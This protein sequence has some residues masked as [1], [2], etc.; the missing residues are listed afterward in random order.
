[1]DIG[2]TTPKVST[3]PRRSYHSRMPDMP[4][5]TA[6]LGY[7][8]AG[9]VFHCPFVSAVPGLELTAIVQRTGDT[10]AQRY[11]NARILRSVDEAFA[12]PSLDL[13]VV[14]TPNHTHF[15]MARRALEANKHVVVDKP[16]TSTS[17]Q[18]RTLLDLARERGRIIAPYH[19]RRFDND[20]RT[21]QK[22]LAEGS[23]GRVVQVIS[24]MD[25]YR[26]MQ[27]PNTWKEKGG[28]TTGI[29]F[30]L[31]PHLVDM[32]VALF[33][34][35]AR[36]TASVRH[37]RETTEI[38][39]AIDIV[40]EYDATSRFG[41]HP[42]RFSCHTTMLGADPAARFRVHGTHG[43]Y[44]KFGLDPQ[45]PDSLAG[46]APPPVGSSEPW[47]VEPE[48]SWGTLTLGVERSEP[49]RITRAPYP[50]LPGDYRLFYLSVRDAI[51]HGKP[52]VI[53]SEDG[54]RSIR[55]LELALE[56]SRQQRT[57]PIDFA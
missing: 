6:V 55:L 23:L 9:K 37:E 36:I 40:L 44:T 31:G 39:D 18:A 47:G 12:D 26:P 22:V 16:F 1:M 48:S 10:A 57:L 24:H 11:P 56:S 33:G 38:D 42:L 50:T 45:E 21:V 53:P 13:I 28:L 52:L 30:D 5:R 41:A 27:R 4:I 35:P 15:E 14:G 3:L 19:N 29:L 43:S 54:F 46:A 51:L 2:K 34:T 8:L 49:I 20:F 32:A 17:A 7:G 25:R